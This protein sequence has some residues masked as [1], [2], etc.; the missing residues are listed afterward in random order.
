MLGLIATRSIDKQV[1]GINQLVASSATRIRDGL[2]A[3][4]AMK[5]LKTDRNDPQLRA[6]IEAHAPNLGYALLLKQIRP[7]IENATP[8]DIARA[9]QTTVPDV[10]VLFWCLPHHGGLGVLVP[11]AVCDGLLAVG[12]AAS[13]SLSGCSFSRRA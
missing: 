3:Y 11:A 5:S 13:R 7:D 9:A 6:T 2:I 12:A 8:A 10:P 4:E 1:P